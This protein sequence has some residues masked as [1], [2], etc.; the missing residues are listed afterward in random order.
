MID[1]SQDKG[2][3]TIYLKQVGDAFHLCKMGW[4]Q[5]DGEEPFYVDYENG[6][7]FIDSGNNKSIIGTYETT[8]SSQYGAKVFDYPSNRVIGLVGNELIHF[9][10]KDVDHSAGR[11]MPE[12]EC[13]A[14]Y[15]KSGNISAK[16]IITS[17]GMINGSLIGGAAAFVA[18]FYN[19]KFQGVFRDYFTMDD[20]SFKDKHSS[21]LNPFGY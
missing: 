8:P 12:E 18:L 1:N 13:L 7:I 16:D 14:F 3:I 17:W 5:K 15:T 19:Y 9:R 11:F 10:R 20:K 4:S 21:Y 2:Y 6:K